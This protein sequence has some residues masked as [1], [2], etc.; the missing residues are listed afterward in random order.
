MPVLQ[1][2]EVPISFVPR[3]KQPRAVLRM[4]DAIT[5]PIAG[6]QPF[7]ITVN[8]NFA[9]VQ[10]NHSQLAAA[11]SQIERPGRAPLTAYANAQLEQISFETV[12]VN[13]F[14]PGYADCEDKLNLLRA[15]ALLP[16]D[17]I[18]VYANVS[19]AKRW[20]FTDLSIVTNMRDPNTDKVV[21]ATASITL[22]ESIRIANNI[23]PGLQRI[24]E[25]PTRA[26]G[27]GGSGGGSPAAQRDASVNDNYDPRKWAQWVDT[28]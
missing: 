24:A 27:S 9:P 17:V 7:Q 8:F 13:D 16:T 21:R 6:A 18:F 12:I 4:A 3:F 14:A 19:G 10:I 23:V 25:P 28:V 26:G 5:L 2:D 11:Y 1:I 15:M 20:K 22:T